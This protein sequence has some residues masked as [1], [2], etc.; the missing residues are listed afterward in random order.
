MIRPLDV[1]VLGA[2]V[3]G[4]TT[5]YAL[6]KRGLSVAIVDRRTGPGYE[7]SYA[8]GAQLSYAYTD[9]LAS[10]ALLR[11]LP[12]L[13]TMGDP[14]IDLKLTAD[15]AFIKWGL[16]FLRNCTGGRFK[17]NTLAALELAMES[18]LALHTLLA[19]HPLDFAYEAAGKLHLYYDDKGLPAADEVR[20]LK[21]RSGVIQYMMTPAEARAI[22][23]ALESVSGIAGAIY[24]PDDEVGDPHA[25]CMN[26][27]QVLVDEY[28]VQTHFGFE[29]AALESRHGLVRIQ[30]GQN[31][32][33]SAR[34]VAICLGIGAPRFLGQIGIRVPIWPM[35]GYSFTAPHGVA[36]PR[37]SIT[38][39]ARKIVLC[40]LGGQMRV[41]GIAQLGNWSNDVDPVQLHRLIH[42]AQSAFPDAARYDK[43]YMTWAGL[44]PMSPRSLPIISEPRPDIFLN[45]GHGMLGW[46]FAMGAAER[47]ANL[48]MNENLESLNEE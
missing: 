11:K 46:T 15:P 38:D 12:F 44:R 1:V 4:V 48:I 41:A 42:K 45:V 26:L 37:I 35:K 21:G 34:R 20:K 3:I 27:L 5:A 33:I 6:A 36:A 2:G 30:N 39:T 23:P 13:V 10:P 31:D 22:E 25:F 8:N 14:A 43:A 32:E 18:R 40:N 29:A 19:R 47:T 16:H 9:A 17:A 24:T 7:T 28:G